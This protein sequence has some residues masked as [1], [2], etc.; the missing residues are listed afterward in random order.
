MEE[1]ARTVE[2]ARAVGASDVTLPNGSVCHW[3][4]QYSVR[5]QHARR[6]FLQWFVPVTCGGCSS[7]RPVRIEYVRR[8]GY[9]GRCQK[10]RLKK[11]LG[12]VVLATGSVIHASE[13]R[14]SRVPVTCALCVENGNPR[15]KRL[16][17]VS[18]LSIPSYTGYCHDCAN[19]KRE[20]D[21]EHRSGAVIHWSER[22][23]APITKHSKVAFTCRECRGK[24]FTDTKTVQRETWLGLC[25]ECYDRAPAHNR[26]AGDV[27][28]ATGSVI[29]YDRRHPD[30]RERIEVECGLC[31]EP[32]YFWK[33]SIRQ[34]DFTGYCPKHKSGEIVALLLAKAQV[35]NGPKDVG[36]A[37]V[38]AERSEFEGIVG[39]LLKTLPAHRVKRPRI[40]AAYDLRRGTREPM[41]PSNI[42]KI[43]GRCYPRGTTVEDAVAMVAKKAG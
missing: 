36:A 37:K 19:G 16:L 41:D 6:S 9:D 38:E 35:G 28:L 33:G 17:S 30:T 20:G 32:N 3:S 27:E 4:G 18:C 10:C 5:T 22:D 13:R 29:H 40:A 39:E 23:G 11:H 26:K 15:P 21:E 43:V 12:D 14:G 42:T 34:A 7:R 1:V 25:D 2:P 24:D 31:H 8:A